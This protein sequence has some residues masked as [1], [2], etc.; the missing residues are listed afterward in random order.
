[1]SSIMNNQAVWITAPKAKPFKVGPG[2]TPNPGEKEMVIK[3]A[4]AAIN[5]SEWKT[6]ELSIVPIDY[7]HVLGSDVAGEVVQVGSGVTRFKL[8]ERVIGQC[9]GLVTKKPTD[10]GFQLYTTCPE[11]LVAKVPDSLPLASAVV[12]PLSISTAATG[13]FRHLG[14]QFPTLNPKPT[15]E[16]ILIWGGSSS[17]GS[18]AIQL[19][20]AAGYKV[21]TTAS[22]RNHDYVKSLGAAYAF[23][24]THPDVVDQII[25]I[26]SGGKLAGV[27]DCISEEKTAR[28]C[29]EILSRFG[30]GVL[31]LLLWAPEGLPSN[32]KTVMVWGVD[33]ASNEALGDA[34]WRKY[35]PEALA[36]GKLQAK[37]DPVIIEGG[38]EKVQEGV[39]LVRKGVSAKKVVVEISKHI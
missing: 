3:V 25:K 23:D 7:P 35:V 30:G 26:L 4:Y 24:H 2:P 32:V 31:P 21:I 38:L 8:G 6:Q 36:Q 37:P 34:I 39:D 15:G 27:F 14:L 18:S 33:P 16:M 11:I 12:L 13:L 20:V 19:A 29:A 5:P 22:S 1:M 28:A 9:L 17:C 10:G